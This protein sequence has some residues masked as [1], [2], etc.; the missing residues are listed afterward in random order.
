MS[1]LY[2]DSE[3]CGLH[4]MPVLFQYAIDDGPII[5]YDVWKHPIGETLDLIEWFMTHT[6]VFFNASFDMFHLCKCYTIFSLCP[7]HWIPEDHINEIAV[8]EEMAQ[9]GPCLK[10]AGCLDLM[11]H[12]RKGPYQSLMSR[13]DIRIRKVPNALAYVLAEELEDQIEIDGIFF[14]KRASKDAPRWNVFDRKNGAEFDPD[15]KDVVLRFNPAGGLKF[16][17][18]YAMKLKPQFQYK[19]VEPDRAFRPKELGY[20]PTASAI[21]K[22]PNW[23]VYKDDKL[24]GRAWPAVIEHFI[25]HWATNENA[26]K[27]AELDIVYT[28]KLDEH[29]NFPEPNDD[30][31]ILACM[32][33][34]VRWHGFK[35]NIPGIKKLNAEAKEIVSASPVNINKPTAVRAYIGECM[36]EI[37]KMV[38][39][40]STK[41]ANVEAVSKWQVTEEEECCVSGRIVKDGKEIKCERCNGTGVL[42]P[43]PHPA[44]R[45]AREILTVKLASKE[46]ELYRKLLKAGKFHASF[47]VIGA[48]SSRMSGADGLNAQGI[49]HTF[50]VRSMFPLAWD[51]MALSIGDFDAFEVTI[52]D[53][54]CDDPDLRQDLL[55]GK[56]IHAIFGSLMFP[57]MTYDEILATKGAEDD[58]Y[59]KGKS[60][61]FATILYGGVAH[62]LLS[63]F[64]VP[65]KIGQ[66][67]IDALLRKYKKV[68]EWRNEVFKRFCSMSQPRGIGSQVVWRE[69]D[70][71]CETFLGFKRYFTLENKICKTL[72]NLARKPPKEWRNCPVKVVRRDRV[73]TAG[74]AVSSALYAAAFNIQAASMRAAANHEIQSPGAE[75]TKRLERKI[76]DLQPVGINDWVVAPMN[77]H[78]EVA[79]VSQPDSVDDIAN[80]VSE[81]VESFRDQVPLIEISWNKNSSNWA[82]K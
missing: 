30:D 81:T 26:R 3:T 49:K 52:A 55:S 6:M 35:I 67:A 27:Y 72:F 31:S 20:A 33:A 73:Q 39:E 50:D 77:I 54:V 24:V 51:G 11:L 22:G 68:G 61:F 41:K 37:E 36:N 25:E 14:A 78:D 17:A 60:G 63:K 44:A 38:I 69:P 53:A 70:D 65:E 47:K 40:E 18:E 48:L 64:G 28:R 1:K 62:T 56:K 46:V 8:C 66:A 12:S 9:N 76:W 75:I 7:Q 58:R 19:D 82:E 21:S 71:Y 15:F 4:G 42:R 79:V 10:P 80:A 45:R 16:L 34:A 43:G 57:D 13:D 59:T 32:V 74:G 23:E 5:L 29:F 2:F